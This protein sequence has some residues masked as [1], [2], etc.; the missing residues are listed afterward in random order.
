M[1]E[2]TPA[3][4][5]CSYSGCPAVFAASDGDS[6]IIGNKLPSDLQAQLQ[7]RIADDEFIIKI[8][9]EFFSCIH[10]SR[11]RDFISFLMLPFRRVRPQSC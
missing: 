7:N 10:R 9:P 2:I 6:V 1:I 5:R 3:H 8:S 11:W 4:L